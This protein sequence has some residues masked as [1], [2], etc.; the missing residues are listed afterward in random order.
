[1]AEGRRGQAGQ[2]EGA[3]G[4][5]PVAQAGPYP[6]IVATAGQAGELVLEGELLFAG[7]AG[8]RRVEHRVGDTGGAEGCV[9]VQAFLQQY[10]RHV[11][12]AEVRQADAVQGVQAHGS[13]HFS[14]CR[15]YR[16]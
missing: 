6:Q 7:D 12:Q 14:Y 16:T 9:H 10:A 1:M 4:E 15:A 5:H 2:A 13:W 11:A 8:V 3:E